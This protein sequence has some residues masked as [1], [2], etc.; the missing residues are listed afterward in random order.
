MAYVDEDLWVA[1][2]ETMYGSAGTVYGAYSVDLGT[3]GYINDIGKGK[4]I[5]LVVCVSTAFAGTTGSHITFQVLADADLTMDAS[6]KII[7]QSGTFDVGD[8]T[9]G[10]VVVI[11][12]GSATLTKYGNTY[13]HIGMACLTADQTSSAGTVDAY[14]TFDPPMPQP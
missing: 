1:R 2:A 13:D 11:P 12:V 10:T 6:S 9:K 8:L 5:Y 7:A 14:F 3:T 4:P